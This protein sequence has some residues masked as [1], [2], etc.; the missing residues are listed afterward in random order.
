MILIA[1]GSNLGD[2][3]LYF[4]K[5][6]T[7]LNAAGITILKFS[8]VIEVPA[9]LPAG[10][11]AE[12]NMPFLNQVIEVETSQTAEILLVMLK[13]IEKE[14]GRQDRGHW[15]PREIDLDLIAYHDDVMSTPSLTVPHPRL[16]ERAFVLKPL[17]EIAP[18]W[19]HPVLNQSANELLETLFPLKLVAILNLTPDS[20]SGDGVMDANAALAQVTELVAAGADVIDI[21]AES[22][23]PGATTLTAE[24]EWSRLRPLLQAIQVH[25]LRDSFAISIDTR[26]AETAR[27]SLAMGVDIINDVSGLSDPRM[28][29]LLKAQ[30]CT[31]IVMHALSVPA[32]PKITIPLEADPVQVILD[33]KKNIET[34]GIVPSRLIFD[35]GIGFGKTAQQSLALIERASELVASGGMWLFG[36]SRKSF[37]KVIADTKTEERDR[38]TI[39]FSEQLVKAGVQHLRVHNIAMHRQSFRK[40][41]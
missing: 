14:L 26:H 31:I 13:A 33:W 23:R 6:Y 41:A 18:D 24:E 40:V 10:A 16:H 9:L 22:T 29:T 17:A 11:P 28:L 1:L 21:G 35:P 3:E 36:H 15:S 7:A 2:R 12:W 32:D 25:P 4:K 19:Q 39:R 30:S 8:S 20:F 5:A 27:Q 37:M 34:L 38:M